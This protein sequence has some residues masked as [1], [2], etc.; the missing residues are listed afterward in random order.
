MP[1]DFFLFR[2]CL[3]PTRLPFLESSSKLV[4]DKLKVRYELMP[5]ATCCVEPIGLRSLG[6]DTWLVSAARLLSIAEKEGKEILS[7]CNGCYMSL[8]E[9][10]HLLRST[11]NLAR[12][13]EVLRTIDREYHG[14][15][16][17]HHLTEVIRDRGESKIKSLVSAPQEQLKIAVHPGCHMVRPSGIMRLDDYFRPTVLNKITAWTGAEVVH[18]EDWPSCCGG[19]LAGVDDSISSKILSESMDSIAR[20]GATHIMTPCPFCFFQFDVKQKKIPVL[21]LS[22]LLALS[23]GASPAEIGLRYHKLPVNVR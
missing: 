23:F 1:R 17:V 7:L 10:H 5:G 2:G 6:I 13:N 15:T 20:S 22:E 16:E 9:A 18:S 12:A 11:E 4:L 8:K 14:G 21:F 19:T 3:I